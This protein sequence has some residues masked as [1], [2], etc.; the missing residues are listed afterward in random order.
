MADSQELLARLVEID[1]VNPSLV[2]GGAGEAEVARFVAG[3]CERA[4]LEVEV[5][6]VAHGRP[7]V[8]ARARGRGGGRT[9]LL[10]AHTDTV[11][12][13]GMEAPLTPRVEGNRMYGRGAFDMK[14][15]LA[16]AMLATVEAGGRG[17]AGDV[18]LTAVVDEEAYSIGSEAVAASIAADAAIVTE[19]T[20]LEL[21]VAHKGFV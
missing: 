2:A 10:N 8:I 14:A 7:N 17:L 19:P 1:S 5:A 9:L 12:T 13:A 20:A 3:W 4:G 6:E 21:C 16:A 11:G 15:G 18:V